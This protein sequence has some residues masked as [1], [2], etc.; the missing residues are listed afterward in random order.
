[1]KRV[2]LTGASGFVGRELPPLLLARGYE[3]HSVGRQEV[4]GV[5][6][7]HHCD[8]L[9]DDLDQLAAAIEPTHLLHMA[10]YA[11]PGHFWSATENLEWAAAS[12]RLILA[13]GKAGTRRVVAAGSCAE[14]DWSRPMLDEQTTPLEPATLYGQAKVAVFRLLASVGPQLGLSFAWGRIFFTYGPTEKPG[15]LVSDLL[16]GLGRDETVQLS[17]GTQERDFMHVSDV[18]AAFAALLDREV[19]GAVNIASGEIVSVRHLAE[20]LAGL[21]GKQDRLAFGMRAMQPGEPARLAPSI[22]R[23]RTEVGFVPQFTLDAGLRDTYQRRQSPS[24]RK[25]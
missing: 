24:V 18:A 7:H 22:E 6:A 12:L 3:V 19:E 4:T 16:D 14:Y 20:R 11:E 25:D 1:M 23:L 9:R 8:L 5:N 17:A 10:W 2:L 21:A 15:R 13:V